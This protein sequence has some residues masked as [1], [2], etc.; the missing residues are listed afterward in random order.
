[1]ASPT[2]WT[3]VWVSSGIRWWTGRPGVL[4]SMGSQRV[5]HNWAIELN[6][7]ECTQGP[8]MLLQMAI[9]HLLLKTAEQYFI[10]IFSYLLYAFIHWWT[11]R[12]FLYLGYCKSCC[13][14]LSK[15]M[16][17]KISRMNSNILNYGLRMITTC[18]CRLMDYSKQIL[19]TS[20]TL[21]DVFFL[22]LDP[23]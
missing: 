19:S 14:D 23:I 5:R 8:S 20:P 3:W 22:I 15:P 13:D 2:R 1:M 16:G 7:A 21:G 6:W 18:H 11:L 10:Y 12:L 9:F 4:Q 17:C